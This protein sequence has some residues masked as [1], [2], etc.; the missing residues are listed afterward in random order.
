VASYIA[1]REGAYVTERVL[2]GTLILGLGLTILFGILKLK[3]M[4]AEYTRRAP[5]KE[6]K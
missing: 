4:Q 3:Q 2:T 6:E 5:H 1:Y